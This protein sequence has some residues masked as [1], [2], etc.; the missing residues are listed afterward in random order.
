MARQRL[1]TLVFGLALVAAA[2]ARADFKA[3]NET[4][5]P[6]GLALA[7]SDGLEWISEGWWAIQPHTCAAVLVGPL[8]ARFYYLHAVDYDLGGGWSGDRFF[9][10]T[11]RSFTITG[12]EKCAERGYDRTGFFEVDTQNALD[13]THVLSNPAAR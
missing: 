9:C 1:L 5:H 2:P 6:L 7:H 3:C 11:R 13:Y 12:R 8:K 4:E 10:T